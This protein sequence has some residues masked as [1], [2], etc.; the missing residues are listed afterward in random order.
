MTPAGGRGPRTR[1]PVRLRVARLR[2]VVPIVLLASGC[3]DQPQVTDTGA[4]LAEVR[5]AVES[6]DDVAAVTRL[7]VDGS[8]SVEIPSVIVLGLRVD[9][10]EG[11]AEAVIREA[12]ELLWDSDVPE[13][14]LVSASAEVEPG[15]TVLGTEVFGGRLDAQRL[16]AE[17][18]P[19]GR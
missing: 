9:G 4:A 18:G 3:V 19:R 11:R 16:E 5:P 6:L 10:G 1:T 17:F 13:I 8:T 12:V 2:L 7:D 15:R 14:S